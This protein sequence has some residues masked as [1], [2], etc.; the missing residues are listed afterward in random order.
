M[1]KIR[2]DF[3]I[4]NTGNPYFLSLFDTSNWGVIEDK[5]AIIE[6]TKPGEEVPVT[7]YFD[8]K[9][10]NNFNSN[11]LEEVCLDDCNYPDLVL[12][13]DGLY[14]I[15]LKGS[16]DKFYKTRMHLKTDSFDL[17]LSKLFTKYFSKCESNNDEIFKKITEIKFLIQGAKSAIRFSNITL[18]NSLWEKAVDRLDKLKNCIDE[19]S[20]Y[21]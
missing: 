13:S 14:I 1:S 19:Q 2:V 3:D 7:F 6:I 12:L 18:A 9:A 8:K 11:K 21:Y 5:P 4:L 10:V 15:T 17:E 20:K 16:P